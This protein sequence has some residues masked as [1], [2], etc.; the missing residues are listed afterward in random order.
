MADVEK[1]DLELAEEALGLESV[2]EK[3]RTSAAKAA[4]FG[5]TYSVKRGDEVFLN[6]NAILAE[7]R[8]IA[9]NGVLGSLVGA[10]AESVLDFLGSVALALVA[11]TDVAK[12]VAVEV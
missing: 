3:V 9:T 6:V 11:H 12:E 8:V 5:A 7:A 1:T 4:S 10:D 2:L